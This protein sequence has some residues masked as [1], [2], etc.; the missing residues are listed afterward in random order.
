MRIVALVVQ[1]ILSAIL[2]ASI[3]F[4]T[5]KSEGLSG[6][7]G[8]KASAT[9]RGAST[10]TDAFLEKATTFVAVAWFI[11]CLITARLYYH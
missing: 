10:A 8:G 5:T 7:I 1:S 9:I 11:G 4:Q 3:L 6:T 2:I